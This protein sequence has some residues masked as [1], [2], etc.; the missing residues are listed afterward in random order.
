M[1]GAVA[2]TFRDEWLKQIGVD[3]PIRQENFS[4]SAKAGTV[5]GLHCQIAPKAQGKLVRVL[6]GEIV[7]VVVDIR[8]GSPSFGKLVVMPLKAGEPYQQLWVPVGFLHGF[9]TLVDDTEVLYKM[10]D[11]YSPE[12]ERGVA[13]DD[14]DLGIPWPIPQTGPIVSER[15][16]R[17]PRL[18]DAP[19]WFT[20]G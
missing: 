8:H 2:E 13:W 11:V 9:V 1:R 12:H 10:T 6:R 15:D 19:A 5:R 17:H 14:P 20:F 7:D 3:T 18:R 16:K 4:Y